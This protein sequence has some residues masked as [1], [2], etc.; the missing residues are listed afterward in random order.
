VRLFLFSWEETHV[1]LRQYFKK[2][3]ETEGG[4]AEQFPLIVSLET[5]EG[6]KSGVVS[7]VSRE[8]AAKMLVE[9]R[10]ALANEAE[11]Q[12]YYDRQAAMKQA[13]ERADLS[14]RLQVAIVTDPN[15]NPVPV[16]EL[17]QKNNV[18]PASRK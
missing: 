18:P 12:A 14:R 11:K 5:P 17:E 1:D 15:F 10:A 7:E 13:A 3:R 8:L 4:L 9:G 6:G 16:S 2:L